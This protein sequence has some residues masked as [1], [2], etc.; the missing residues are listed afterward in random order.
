MP[1]KKKPNKVVTEQQREQLIADRVACIRALLGTGG[2]V[3]R[4]CRC[5]GT[6]PA[7]YHRFVTQ[8]A[9]D[10]ET[11]KGEATATMLR[12]SQW[13]DLEAGDD[14]L[15]PPSTEPTTLAETTIPSVNRQ[16]EE[17]FEV[18]GCLDCHN[19]I[20][21]A[22]VTGGERV[23]TFYCSS[24]GAKRIESGDAVLAPDHSPMPPADGGE[25]VV[26]IDTII[27]GVAV[28]EPYVDGTVQNPLHTFEDA[29]KLAEDVAKQQAGTFPPVDPPETDDRSSIPY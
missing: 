28:G 3:A 4:I 8:H 7:A 18:V 12:P 24:C 20:G 11:W 27:P 25:P 5:L 13:R 10:W 14:P 17:E 22:D 9:P 6:S 26:Y 16:R 19:F 21:Y 2:T 23:P 29:K 15:N 1:K